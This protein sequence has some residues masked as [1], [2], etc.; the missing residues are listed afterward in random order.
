MVGNMHMRAMNDLTC[1]QM[2]NF[3]DGVISLMLFS[4][5]SSLIQLSLIAVVDHIFLVN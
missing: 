2:V 5:I 3:G 4:V 1:D